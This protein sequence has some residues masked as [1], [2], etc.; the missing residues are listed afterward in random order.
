MKGI[1]IKC[2]RTIVMLVGFMTFALLNAH[3]FAAADEPAE[4]AFNRSAAIKHAQ[5]A[6]EEFFA[7]SMPQVSLAEYQ[8]QSPKIAG[9]ISKGCDGKDRNLILVAFP[10][11]QKEGW[12]D[13]R[14]I[15]NKDG[16]ITEMIG[17]G[18]SVYSWDE[19]VRNARKGSEYC[20]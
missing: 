20:E 6:L 16:L 15:R 4:F 3:S 2:A 10:A 17:M 8:I 11:K 18:V 19:M 14:L 1:R 5:A 13:V 9:I 12:A 7:L